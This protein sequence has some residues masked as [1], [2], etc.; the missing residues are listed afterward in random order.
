MA[1][2]VVVVQRLALAALVLLVAC[3]G[4]TVTGSKQPVSTGGQPPPSSVSPA[5]ARCPKDLGR[6]KNH[7]VRGVRHT[8]VPGDPP[9]LVLCG[10][11][12]RVVVEGSRVHSLAAILNALKVVPPGNVYVCPQDLG[13]IYGLFFDYANGHVLLVT[14][15]AG[16]CRVA[17]NGRRSSWSDHSVLAGIRTLLRSS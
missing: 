11:G 3:T 7:S 4:S 6:F 13:P 12:K 15:D 10:V 8:L 9:V 17:S 5:P 2:W 1:W 14:V 16:G